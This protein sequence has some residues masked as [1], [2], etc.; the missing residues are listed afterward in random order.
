MDISL[1]R[2]LQEMDIQGKQQNELGAFLGFSTGN[3]VT[4]W[5][6]GRVKSYTKY[7]YEYGTNNSYQSIL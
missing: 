1:E 5:K 7:L 3:I 6:S 2:I 4:D